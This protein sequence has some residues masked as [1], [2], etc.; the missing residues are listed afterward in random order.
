MEADGGKCHPPYGARV[1]R[2]QQAPYAQYQEEARDHSGQPDRPCRNPEQ[3]HRE[4]AKQGEQ[5]MIGSVVIEI[6]IAPAVAQEQVEAECFVVHDGLG[7][8]PV[9]A[10]GGTRQRQ[11]DC[12]YALPGQR[13]G[14]MRK[15]TRWIHGDLCG[16]LSPHA[17]FPTKGVRLSE[18]ID[19]M[20]RLA[21]QLEKLG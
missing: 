11:C 4:L 21:T 14:N 7:R 8:C 5:H 6:Y 20:R 1:G 10:E 15:W 9:C 18:S 12:D 17:S 16:F 13:A 2:L 3:P 19:S